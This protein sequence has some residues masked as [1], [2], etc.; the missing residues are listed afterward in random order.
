MNTVQPYL[1]QFLNH[2]FERRRSC[3]QG[4]WTLATAGIPVS[5]YPPHRIEEHV[6]LFTPSLGRYTAPHFVLGLILQVTV[7]YASIVH[8]T[9]ACKYPKF[10]FVLSG[11]IHTAISFES[12]QGKYTCDFFTLCCLQNGS[13]PVHCSFFACLSEA[14]RWIF[15]FENVVGTLWIRCT[16]ILSLF[17]EASDS[18]LSGIAGCPVRSFVVLQANIVLVSDWKRR[19]SGRAV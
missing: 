16:H 6:P 15:S 13:H 11:G 4:P 12:R 9:T 5:H 2:V 14:C 3:E 8:K 10:V 17:L 1:K 19:S 18:N 7:S